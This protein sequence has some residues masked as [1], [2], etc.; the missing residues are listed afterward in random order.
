MNE[1]KSYDGILLVAV[2]AASFGLMPIFVK[3]AY[4]ANT[5]TYSLLFLRF[6]VA[7]LFMFSLLFI[8]KLALPSKKE[9]LIYFLLGA[10][11]YV[12][13]S[14]CYFTAL[15]YASPSVVSLLLYTYPALVMIGSAIFLHEKTTAL[16]VLSLCLALGGSFVIIGAELDANPTG[17]IFSI[18]S[19]ILYSAYI[20]ISSK[21]VKP[22]T[23][24]QSS[25]FIVLGAAVVY[26][27]IN[28]FL[29]F[30]PPTQTSG[31]VSVAM[32]AMISTVLAF[33]SFFTGMEK[34]GPSTAALVSTLEPVVTVLSS[35]IILSERITINIII[36]GGLVLA[37]LLITAIPSKKVD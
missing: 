34:T 36:G 29:G 32:I 15:N 11:G 7:T 23:G 16:K 37:A 1:K 19:A 20:L 8:R 6:L 14:F 2:S 22:G 9:M 10:V 18:L 35:A 25:A 4:S 28:L 21:V 31:V 17:I 12:G 30:T 26:G 5:N 27:M 3:I 33:W 24:I 13:Q